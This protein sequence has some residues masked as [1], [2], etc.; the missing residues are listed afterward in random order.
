MVAAV[1]SVIISQNNFLF[2]SWQNDTLE[3]PKK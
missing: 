2:Q 1:Q 3:Y